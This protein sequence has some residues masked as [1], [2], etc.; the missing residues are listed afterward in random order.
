MTK[1]AIKP[2]DQGMKITKAGLLR[3]PGLRGVRGVLPAL[4]A[5]GIGLGMVP[6]HL[7]QPVQHVERLLEVGASH[8]VSVHVELAEERLVQDGAHGLATR[9]I[10]LVGPLQ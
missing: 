6:L 1:I 5:L 3:E 2:D 7:I 10:Q 4:P 8:P 9:G